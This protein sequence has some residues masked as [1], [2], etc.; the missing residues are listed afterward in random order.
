MSAENIQAERAQFF[1]QLHQAGNPFVLVNV[2]DIGGAKIAA[3]AGAVALATTSAGHAATLGKPDMGH[4][5]REES[6]AHAAQIAAATELPVSGDCEN[7]YGHSPR[8]VAETVRACISAGLAGCS[9]ED[10]MLPDLT[11]YSLADSVLRIESAIAAARD[12]T[13][14]FVLTARADGMMN[15]SYDLTEAIRRLR[16]FAAAGADV[17]YAPEA[18]DMDALARICDSVSAPVNALAAGKFRR[19]SL[20][21]FARAGIARVSLGSALAQTAQ[22]AAANS[23]RDILRNGSFTSLQTGED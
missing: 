20:A 1:R 17:V 21:D 2:W 14:D 11:P 13:R 22:N 16:A 18:P 4:I 5:S 19:F 12:A 9:I 15:G 23:V 10:T 8:E 3:A 7:G 6:A